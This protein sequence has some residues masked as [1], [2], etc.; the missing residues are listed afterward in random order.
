MAQTLN[1]CL[2]FA[3]LGE[4]FVIREESVIT[5]NNKCMRKTR[6]QDTNVGKWGIL[7]KAEHRLWSQKDLDS[8]LDSVI[9]FYLE[10]ITLL[11]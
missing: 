5:R 8:N 3:P 2:S 10:L 7:G 1:C 9:Y 11:L 6:K 4:S